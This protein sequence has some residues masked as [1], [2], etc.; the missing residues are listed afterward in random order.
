MILA[1]ISQPLLGLVDTAVLGHLGAPEYLAGTAVGAFIIAQLYWLC[2]FFRQSMTGLAAQEKG[3]ATVSGKLQGMWD[4]LLRACLLAVVIGLILWLLQRPIQILLLQWTTLPALAAQS[5]ETYFQ[6]RIANAPIALLN[7]VTIGYLV[8]QHRTKAVMGLQIG[9]NALNIL[10]NLL[11]VYVF[12]WGVAGVAYATIVAEWVMLLCSLYWIL[13]HSLRRIHAQHPHSLPRTVKAYWQ[14]YLISPSA[15]QLRSFRHVL[16]LNRDLFIRSI[17][18]QACLAFLTYQG[19]RFGV[20][21]A[22]VNAILMQFFV[23]IALGLDGVAYAIEAMIGEAKGAQDEQL[24]LSPKMWRD[25]Q[26]SLVWSTLFGL[27]T[28]LVMALGYTWFVT[29]LT[30]QGSIIE[31]TQPYY[32]LMV[33]LPFLAHWCYCLDGIYIGFTAGKVMRNSMLVSAVVGFFVVYW[34][35]TQHN[36]ASN[37]DLWCALL[38]LQ[39]VRGLTL[40]GHLYW[41]YRQ[42]YV[43]TAK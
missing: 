5:L 36:G 21:A 19:A 16:S 15:L 30:N 39:T 33:W 37:I 12:A 34:I 14:R 25:I 42:D 7:L 4:D 40:G 11:F 31:A 13:R 35:A 41:L 27:G 8:G 43:A 38:G 32:W 6:I 22:A 20:E 10:L 18:L 29:I 1:N 3:K 23:F 17:I 26:I 9:V 28:M 24:S 2:G